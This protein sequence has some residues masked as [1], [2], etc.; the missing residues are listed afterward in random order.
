MPSNGVIP[1]SWYS[2]ILCSDSCWSI[3]ED[4]L[5][6]TAPEIYQQYVVCKGKTKVLWMPI[7]KAFYCMLQSSL[8]YYKRFCKVIQ[9]IRFMVDPYNPCVANRIVN[10]KQQM[11]CGRFEI[12]SC[13]TISKS[14]MAWMA[15]KIKEMRD[16][17]NDYLAMVI[18]FSIPGVTSKHGF[19]CKVND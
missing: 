17:C 14:W 1:W 6:E 19:Q 4:I 13:R 8:L 7:L 16:T 18:D 9:K 5:I 11:A 15:G 10:G 3:F 2:K 12:Q